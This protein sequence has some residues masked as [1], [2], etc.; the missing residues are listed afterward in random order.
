M[1]EIMGAK[2]AVNSL[3][4]ASLE[5]YTGIILQNNQPKYVV[6]NTIEIFTDRGI[7]ALFESE[8]VSISRD[9]EGNVYIGDGGTVL[10]VSHK[11]ALQELFANISPAMFGLILEEDGE[12]SLKAT[13]TNDP[14][15]PKAGSFSDVAA[16]TSIRRF[17]V[18]P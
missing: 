2:E 17:G 6:T 3:V 16:V 11:T 7:V 18:T 15:E 9:S 10:K 12:I 5:K 8:P 4:E 14:P 13:L 1:K